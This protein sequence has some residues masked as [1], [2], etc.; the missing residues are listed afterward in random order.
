M[1]NGRAFKQIIT[2]IDQLHKDIGQLVV[3]IDQ[4][5]EEESYHPIDANRASHGISAHIARPK[6]WRIPNIRR[7]F[8]LDDDKEIRESL[9]YYINLNNDSPF[10]FPSMMCGQ[11]QYKLIT[12]KKIASKV[13]FKSY[14]SSLANGRTTRWHEFREDNGWILAKPAFESP[15]QMFKG[16]TLNLYDLSNRQQVGDY[17]IRPLT[18]GINNSQLLSS[19][20]TQPFLTQMER[21]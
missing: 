21:E 19:I 2:Y 16:Y 15:V 14:L 20:P 9:F 7:F 17:V 12:E 4:L 5:M 3:L 1:D 6:K 10:E 13:M 11:F 8:V 18:Q